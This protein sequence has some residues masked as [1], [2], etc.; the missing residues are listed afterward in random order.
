M[1]SISETAKLLGVSVH[2]LRLAERLGVVPEARRTVGGHRRYTLADVEQLRRIG[3]GER[4]RSLQQVA[5]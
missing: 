5:S 1:F 2:Y 3:V 4:K